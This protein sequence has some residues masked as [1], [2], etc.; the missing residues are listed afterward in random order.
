M[1][2]FA[3]AL[4]ENGVIHALIV[5]TVMMVWTKFHHFEKTKVVQLKN[6]KIKEFV[7][8]PKKLGINLKIEKI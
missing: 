5:H 2:P 1:R 8:D 6:G 3:E 4:K 7:I